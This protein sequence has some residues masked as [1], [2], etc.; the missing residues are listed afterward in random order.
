M[1]DNYDYLNSVGNYR[2]PTR[3]MQV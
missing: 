1:S 3:Q 2:S